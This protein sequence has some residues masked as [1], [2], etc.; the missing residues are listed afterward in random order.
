M[1]RATASWTN[2]EATDW[3]AGNFIRQTKL[4][5]Q[6]LQNLEYFAQTHNHTGDP[7]GA[8]LA[9]ADPKAV[10]FYGGEDGGPFA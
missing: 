2:T 10:W 6:V 7:A 8:V 9:F 3:T 5:Q 1:A 4:L